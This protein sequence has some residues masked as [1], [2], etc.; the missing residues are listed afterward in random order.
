[1]PATRIN[2]VRVSQ[3]GVDVGAGAPADLTNGN[4]VATVEGLQLE[5]DNSAGSSPVTVTFQ[6]SAVVEGYPVA[7]ITTTV[8]ASARRTFGHFS[9]ALFGEQV[10]FTCSAECTVSATH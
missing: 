10:Q 9:R 7:D 2:P 6:T 1:M 5:V 8:P 4:V 3:T